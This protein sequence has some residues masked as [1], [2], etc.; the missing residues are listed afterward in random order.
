MSD[1]E[2]ITDRVTVL[3]KS[4]EDNHIVTP[5]TP[6]T[7][8]ASKRKHSNDGLDNNPSKKV[9]ITEKEGPAAPKKRVPTHLE[10]VF[11]K[12]RSLDDK[13]LRLELHTEFLG[14]YRANTLVYPRT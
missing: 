5:E 7:S 6:S 13:L 10:P 14:K 2:E 8:I 3:A 12:L 11:R 1:A 4:L 9:D